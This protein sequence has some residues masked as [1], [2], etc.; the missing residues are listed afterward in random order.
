MGFGK[1]RR[2][3]VRGIGILLVYLMILIAGVV[4]LWLF[5]PA[6]VKE[7]FRETYLNPR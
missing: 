7:A 1:R 3:R 2:R 4:A 6:A 5:V